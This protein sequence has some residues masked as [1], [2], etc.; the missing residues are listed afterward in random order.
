MI[1]DNCF[2]SG[3]WQ[4]QWASFTAMKIAMMMPAGYLSR[5]HGAGGMMRD[6]PMFLVIVLHNQIL[7]LSNHQDLWF[8]DG[9]PKYLHHRASHVVLFGLDTP[10]WLTIELI[11]EI[12]FICFHAVVTDWAGLRTSTSTRSASAV[13]MVDLKLCTLQSL[14][15][16]HETGDASSFARNGVSI[17]R[18]K[19]C[20]KHPRC[21]CRCSLPF[22]VLYQTCRHFWGC[23]KSAQDAILWSLQ[24]GSNR[25]SW[26]IQKG[27]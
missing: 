26:S 10:S 23:S 18:I 25:K 7:L 2:S 8:L 21:K 5:D 12:C 13:K 20:L 3:F 24:S 4:I 6:L 15:G 27:V 19:K 16:S 22:K 1:L 9:I 14:Q 11:I 17:R